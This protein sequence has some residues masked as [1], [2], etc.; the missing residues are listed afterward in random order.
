MLGATLVIRDDTLPNFDYELLV[1][2]D[3]ALKDLFNNHQDLM[4]KVQE[5]KS[6]DD[7]S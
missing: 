4:L 1:S 7:F 6:T 3:D 2:N 5:D